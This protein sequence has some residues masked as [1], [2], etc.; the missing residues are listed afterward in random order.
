VNLFHTFPTAPSLVPF[1]TP[2]LELILSTLTSSGL[3]ALIFQDLRQSML[4]AIED[5]FLS[6]A[7]TMTVQEIESG[8]TTFS[9]NSNTGAQSMPSSSIQYLT[10]LNT[11]LSVLE[12]H[13]VQS[14][15]VT[16]SAEGGGGESGEEDGDET[17]T[18][19]GVTILAIKTTIENGRRK[20]TY[21]F[22]FFYFLPS[23]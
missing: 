17:G 7:S 20:M 10:M 2:F 9:N 14:K 18:Y 23:A 12:K 1:S 19:I 21:G 6:L 13:L 15:G 3:Q 11:T 16:I 22:Y 4:V 8:F 5:I